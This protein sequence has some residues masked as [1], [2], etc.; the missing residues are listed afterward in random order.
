M[1]C[2]GQQ[3]RITRHMIP[4]RPPLL[5]RSVRILLVLRYCVP[6]LRQSIRLAWEMRKIVVMVVWGVMLAP[7]VVI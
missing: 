5:T 4:A 1:P 7:R 6:R 3:L 2:P